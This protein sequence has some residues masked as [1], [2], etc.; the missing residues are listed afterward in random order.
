MVAWEEEDKIE[1]Y[2]NRFILS[3]ISIRDIENFCNKKKSVK[4]RILSI[5]TALKTSPDF[6]KSVIRVLKMVL[7]GIIHN[8]DKY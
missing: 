7:V 1:R 5:T 3:Q 2:L 8:Y 6:C 4:L